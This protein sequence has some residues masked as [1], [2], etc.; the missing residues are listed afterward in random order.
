MGGRALSSQA[1]RLWNQ[2]LVTRRC[3]MVFR[4]DIEVLLLLW[5]WQPRCI[6]GI[7]LPSTV[8]YTNILSS[9][10]MKFGALIEVLKKQVDSHCLIHVIRPLCHH[11][12]AIVC[13][14]N[15]KHVVQNN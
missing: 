10:T 14:R 5:V 1:S 6:N 11:L 15:L 2:T 7:L 9:D 3:G 13:I 12:S 8:H 4:S